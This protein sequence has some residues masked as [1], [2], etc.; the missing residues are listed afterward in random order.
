V[1]SQDALAE[2]YGAPRPLRR[3]AVLV[4]SAVVALAFLGWL[5]WTVWDE[6]HPEVTSSLVTWDAKD[7]H[8]AVATVEVQ[9]SD[10]AVRPSC[11]LRASAEDHQV[12]GELTFTPEDG[13]SVQTIRTERLATQVELLGCTAEGQNR[14]R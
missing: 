14:P 11:T 7:E 10:D 5:A 4:A 1:T 9:L 12:V 8:T 3:R 13:R 6:L 2:R